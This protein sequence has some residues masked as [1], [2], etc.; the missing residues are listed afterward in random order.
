[1]EAKVNSLIKMLSDKENEQPDLFYKKV[2]EKFEGN[3]KVKQ[4]KLLQ[5]EL[6]RKLVISYHYSSTRE[7]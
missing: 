5:K 6:D 3:K 2:K 1:M 4:N 7:A